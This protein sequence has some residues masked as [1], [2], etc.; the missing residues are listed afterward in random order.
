[1][2]GGRVGGEAGEEVEECERRDEVGEEEERGRR[3][4]RS[5]EGTVVKGGA[6][7]GAFVVESLGEV[8]E[9]RRDASTASFNR[10]LSSR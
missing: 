5:D 7:G 2:I 10:A 6:E 4:V 9:D 8:N 3:P 1:M